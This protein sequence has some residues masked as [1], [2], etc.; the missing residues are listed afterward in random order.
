MWRRIY[1]FKTWACVG[2]DFLVLSGEGGKFL[3]G[4]MEVCVFIVFISNHPPPKYTNLTWK[5]NYFP[6]NIQKTTRKC[7]EMTPTDDN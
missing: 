3:P 1:F 4:Q 7:T 2:G 6:Q 5:P